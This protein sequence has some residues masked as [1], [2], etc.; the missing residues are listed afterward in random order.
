M[1]IASLITPVFRILFGWRNWAVFGYNAFLE[2]IFIAFA[3][4]VMLPDYATAFVGWLV[5]FYLFSL[6][7]TSYGYLVNDYGDRS[8]DIRHGKPN[9]FQSLTG[10][11]ALLLV[12]ISL[13]LCLLSAIPFRGADG[14]LPLFALWLFAA[15]F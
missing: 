4:A 14:F 13:L 11:R 3:A 1:R 2:N 15:T 12:G 10:N 6:C 8:L 7:C 5:A 9:S